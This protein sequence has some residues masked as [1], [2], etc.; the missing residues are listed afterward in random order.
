MNAAS[1][2]PQASPQQEVPLDSR[3]RFG[4]NWAKF[5]TLLDDNRIAIAEDS[6]KTWLGTESLAGKRFLDIG[7][8]SGLFSLCARRLG[9]TVRSFDFDPDSVGCAMELR[10]RYF[11]DDKQWEI[12]QGSVLDED[13]ISSLGQ[14]DIVYSWGVLHH[15]GRMWEALGNAERCVP[16]GGTLFIAIYNDQ[17]GASRR[18]TRVKRAYC[19]APSFLKW[20]ILLFY[21]IKLWGPTFFIGLLKGKPFDFWTKYRSARGMSPWHDLVDWVGGY[22]FEVAKPE[23]IFDF[24][25][26]RGFRLLQMKTCGG[27]LG[28]NEFVFRRELKS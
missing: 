9:A 8:G 12:H 25:R 28:C 20:I 3:F 7:C 16:Q 22:P 13:L 21:M 4:R 14:W 6:L 23:E 17:G 26:D 1:S 2:T 24:F 11:P 18:W 27:G 15:T 5:L 10:R 19:A